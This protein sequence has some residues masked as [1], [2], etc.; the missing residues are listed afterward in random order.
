MIEPFK[1]E[2]TPHQ[3]AKDVIVAIQRLSITLAEAQAKI[4]RLKESYLEARRDC[5]S[6][7]QALEFIRDCED[8]GEEMGPLVTVSFLKEQARAALDR[9]PI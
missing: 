9:T 7:A 5:Q 6:L 4:D 2:D 3:E 1:L 8:D